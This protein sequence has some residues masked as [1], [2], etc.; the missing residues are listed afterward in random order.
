LINYIKE[1]YEIRLE[2]KK[3]T[4]HELQYHSIKY[5]ITFLHE[6]EQLKLEI[7]QLEQKLKKINQ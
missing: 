3:S 7:E 5:P 6:I 1:V 4:L 2:V